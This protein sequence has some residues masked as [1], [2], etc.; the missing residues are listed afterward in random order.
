MTK[1]CLQE[2]AIAFEWTVLKPAVLGVKGR[3]NALHSISLTAPS[4]RHCVHGSFH[5][6]LPSSS[7]SIMA[8]LA[9]SGVSCHTAWAYK[10]NKA[11]LLCFA[12]QWGHK[13]RA[14]EEQQCRRL[15]CHQACHWIPW[16]CVS[17]SLHLPRQQ[18]TSHLGTR[19]WRQCVLFSS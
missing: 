7:R 5:W 9:F 1:I 6:L 11:L 14:V 3:N 19:G 10:Q 4:W 8:T 12:L 13:R 2:E 15:T 17:F 18:E 16:T